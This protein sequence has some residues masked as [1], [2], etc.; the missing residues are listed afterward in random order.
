MNSDEI[1]EGFFFTS[2]LLFPSLKQN[3]LSNHVE[4]ECIYY[5]VEH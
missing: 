3:L 5:F 4:E 1:G 2:Q